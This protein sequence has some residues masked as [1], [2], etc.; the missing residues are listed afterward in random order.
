M[1][2]PSTSFVLGMLWWP[3]WCLRLFP[4]GFCHDPAHWLQLAG[5]QLHHSKQCLPHTAETDSPTFQETCEHA[6]TAASTSC[7]Y[8]W[9]LLCCCL[10]RMLLCCLLLF[11]ADYHDTQELSPPSRR[12][13]TH[14]RHGWRYVL[15][16]KLGYLNIREYS[17][18]VCMYIVRRVAL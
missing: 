15:L 6:C 4:W 13:V 2:P 10:Y 7:C 18:A 5:G 8:C 3:R 1:Y 9:L 17:S 11:I 16:S 14:F 12:Q